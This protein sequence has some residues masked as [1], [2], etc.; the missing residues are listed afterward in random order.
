[1]QSQLMQV[2]SAAFHEYTTQIDDKGKNLYQNL[3]EEYFGERWKAPALTNA[4][5]E[6]EFPKYEELLESNSPILWKYLRIGTYDHAPYCYRGEDG[7]WKGWEFDIAEAVREIIINHYS[8]IA[9]LDFEWIAAPIDESDL[10]MDGSDNDDIKEILLEGLRNKE[11]HMVFSGTLAKGSDLDDY[12]FGSPTSDFYVSGVYTGRDNFGEIPIDSGES[13]L[14]KFAE[15]SNKKELP[16][17]IVHTSNGGQ[18]TIANNVGNWIT[19]KYGGEVSDWDVHIPSLF[20]L[21]QYG[22]PHI[23][24]GDILQIMLLTKDKESYPNLQN[25][26]LNFD[27]FNNCLD[28]LTNTF[29][30]NVNSP[31]EP[32]SEKLPMQIAPYAL[33]TT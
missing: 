12:E 9:T 18:T 11:Y 14:K 3:F 31:D 2:F 19:S 21:I 20:T 13:M 33:R 29:N 7:N 23:Y 16:I 28:P 26:K 1:M 22:D 4:N 17:R 5:T 15:R 8:E 6:V 25:L 27:A 32:V 10:P 24:I 30:E